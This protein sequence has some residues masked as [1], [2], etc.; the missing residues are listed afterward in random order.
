VLY[1]SAEGEVRCGESTIGCRQGEKWSA[2]ARYPHET[3]A[4]GCAELVHLHVGELHS[5]APQRV[6]GGH[7]RLP[8]RAPRNVRP[9][10]HE[11]CQ[12]A[13]RISPC[14]PAASHSV[15]RGLRTAA[16]IACQCCVV[17]T[18]S[19]TTTHKICGGVPLG[20]RSAVLSAVAAG[21]ATAANGSSSST[22]DSSIAGRLRFAAF[23]ALL[24]RASCR[25][26]MLRRRRRRTDAAVLL[27]IWRE[28]GLPTGCTYD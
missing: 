27:S 6:Q 5:A 21:V 23:A 16:G 15:H 2:A 7:Q 1:P 14:Q 22:D 28:P 19:S 26:G 20:G 8:P 12:G 9:S 18:R 11:P 24:R 25:G 13:L 3:G 17:L 10:L 4:G